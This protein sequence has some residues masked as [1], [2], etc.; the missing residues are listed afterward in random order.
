MAD[1][2]Y[3]ITTESPLKGKTVKF[4]AQKERKN[5]LS[6]SKIND[7]DTSA[8]VVFAD[9]GIFV[10]GQQLSAAPS[11]LV[12]KTRSVST[13][14][15]S[16]VTTSA[17]YEGDDTENW[18]ITLPVATQKAEG[19]VHIDA[20][21]NPTSL[22]SGMVP[23]V[24]YA[25]DVKTYVDNAITGVKSALTGVF[26]FQGKIP[27]KTGDTTLSDGSTTSPITVNG[28]SVNPSKGDVYSQTEGEGNNV[29]QVEYV[30]DGSSWQALG[31]TVF[32][33]QDKSALDDLQT[34]GFVHTTDSNGALI[35]N[36]GGLYI[37]ENNSDAPVK[38]NVGSG[39]EIDSSNKV[40]VVAADLISA[41][42]AISI[43]EK[44]GKQQISVNSD[45]RKFGLPY[46]EVT[47]DAT[48]GAV[49]I[50]K[51]YRLDMVDTYSLLRVITNASK[52]TATWKY[53]D[54]GT[55][56]VSQEGSGSTIAT[57]YYIA[58]CTVAV[59]TNT[60][61]TL[62]PLSEKVIQYI[63]SV[64]DGLSVSDGKLTINRATSTSTSPAENQY[65]DCQQVAT[66]VST[67][68]ANAALV[69]E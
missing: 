15:S 41:G 55:I 2:A 3:T 54:E 52:T 30:W 51:S 46:V 45:V 35:T 53:N 68:I 14:A 44:N 12:I 36:T 27:Q 61:F 33:K 4:A 43:V 65:W 28:A 69:W 26:T 23:G 19:T 38:I 29:I 9:S 66:V 60:T 62:Y 48:T 34:I 32:T 17:A 5:A 24:P 63:T 47:P 49:T 11:K 22:T 42:T 18:G 64:G 20:M 10:A 37:D 31:G 16:Y 57:G 50:D 40:N 21:D 7:G 1:L 59:G 25:T 13:D 67:A 8:K 56:T 39:L 58:K 6:A